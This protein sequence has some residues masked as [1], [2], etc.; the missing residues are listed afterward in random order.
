MFAIFLSLHSWIRWL[1]LVCLFTSIIRAYQGWLGQ[2][3]FLRFDKILRILTIITL[4]TQLIVGYF[5]YFH[6]P[7]VDYFLHHFSEAVHMRDIRFFGLE[8]VTMM[9]LAILL[10]SVEAYISSRKKTDK[11]KFQILAIFYTIAL[12]MIL[13]S[14]PWSFSPF[15]ARPEFRPLPF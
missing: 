2:R 11:G 4:Y 8:H 15:T 9:T 5:L 12:L 7:L 6:S 14:I 1:V 3:K 10:I 13:A